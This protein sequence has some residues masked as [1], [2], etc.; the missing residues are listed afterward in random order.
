MAEPIAR[1]L[2]KQPPP[3]KVYPKL[4]RKLGYVKWLAMVGGAI[5]AIGGAYKCYE[6]YQ[7][8]SRGVSIQGTL[9]NHSTLATGKGRT[10]Y[11]IIVDYDPKELPQGVRKRFNVLES[12]YRDAKQNGAVE[13]TYLPSDP[14]IS[15]VGSNFHYDAEPIAIGIGV[16]VF[17]LVLHFYLRWKLAQ[18]VNYVQGGTS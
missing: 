2:A 3:P 15:A 17:G 5:V 1:I 9:F 12:V 7:L 16:F 14:T 4:N 13:V 18:V 6:I 10:S 11:D 8:K